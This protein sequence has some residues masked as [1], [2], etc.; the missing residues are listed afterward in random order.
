VLALVVRFA[1]I[2]A[3]ALMAGSPL[4]SLPPAIVSSL[5]GAVKE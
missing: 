3:G 5:T 4:G 1:I 2:R